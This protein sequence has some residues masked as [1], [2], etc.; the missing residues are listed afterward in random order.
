MQ[1]AV[2]VFPFSYG[3][4]SNFLVEPNSSSQMVR[5][6]SY[7][8]LPWETVKGKIFKGARDN[9]VKVY[10]KKIVLGL[11]K[12]LIIQCGGHLNGPTYFEKIFSQDFKGLLKDP[13]S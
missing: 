4:R 3:T 7:I 2:E 6:S 9:V 5:N 12:L 11:Y 1:T 10:G 13:G 8:F